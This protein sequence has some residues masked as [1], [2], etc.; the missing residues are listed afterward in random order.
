MSDQVGAVFLEAFLTAINKS[1]WCGLLHQ[2]VKTEWR[3]SGGR[4][5]DVVCQRQHGLRRFLLGIENKL[6]PWS[7]EQDRQT[8]DYCEDLER[9]ASGD[10]CLVYLTV[11]GECPSET[12]FPRQDRCKELIR[13]KKL[14]LMPYR[15]RRALGEPPIVSLMEWLAKCRGASEAANVREFLSTLQQYATTTI[16]EAAMQVSE[17]EAIGDYII[18]SQNESYLALAKTISVGP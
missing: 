2:S 17:F 8:S 9:R 4:Y 18:A 12:S 14:V 3:T 13:D 10:W 6:W 5:I 16:L 7:Q 1:E 15:Q 11:D